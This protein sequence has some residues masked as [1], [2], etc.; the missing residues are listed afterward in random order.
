MEIGLLSFIKIYKR[1]N[2]VRRHSVLY[3]FLLVTGAIVYSRRHG[4]KA[5]KEKIVQSPWIKQ[6]RYVTAG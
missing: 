3:C 1:G 4:K 5:L 2:A 6:A